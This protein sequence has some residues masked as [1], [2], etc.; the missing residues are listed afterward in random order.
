MT[1]VC[2]CGWTGTSSEVGDRGHCPN[3]WN[4]VKYTGGSISAPT[5]II[6]HEDFNRRFLIAS[7]GI[8]FGASRFSNTVQ[9][10]LR[11]VEM[12]LRVG[13]NDQK[14]LFR[15]A[16]FHRNQITDTMVTDYAASHT[17]GADHDDC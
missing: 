15:A 1:A 9:I 7:K 8:H 6:S 4:K 17:R 12:K 2:D 14:M 10:I 16:H 11:T 13:A 5:A 3:C